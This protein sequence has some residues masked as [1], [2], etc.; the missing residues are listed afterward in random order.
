MLAINTRVPQAKGLPELCIRNP[1]PFPSEGRESC[2]AGQ[3]ELAHEI[4]FAT[5]DRRGPSPSEMHVDPAVL[6]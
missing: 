3:S 5:V 2:E 1:S 6:A 4:G